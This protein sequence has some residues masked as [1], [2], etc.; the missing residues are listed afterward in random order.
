M[1]FGVAQTMFVASKTMNE[2]ENKESNLGL[3]DRRVRR[4]RR[5]RSGYTMEDVVIAMLLLALVAASAAPRFT[6]ASAE[7]RLPAMVESLHRVRSQIQ[8]YKLEHDGL[9]P[10]QEATGDEICCDDFI[11]AM[12][13]SDGRGSRGYLKAIPANPF[14][15]DETADEITVVNSFDAKCSGLEGTGWWFNAATGEFRASDSSFHSDY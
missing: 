2:R 10:G 8:V 11:K 7:N 6:K 1:I 14:V 9:L 4:V 12:T 3:G 13:E 15:D 5:M